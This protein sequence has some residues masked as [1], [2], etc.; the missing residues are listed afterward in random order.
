[1]SSKIS[2]LV[3]D[4]YFGWSNVIGVI[5]RGKGL[6]ELV[7]EPLDNKDGPLPSTWIQVDE[8]VSV[9]RSKF[10]IRTSV[11]CSKEITIK[12]DLAIA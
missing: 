5:L 7:Q 8:D 3:A 4:N 10:E 12:R 2:P 6:R 1:M 11:E 9:K